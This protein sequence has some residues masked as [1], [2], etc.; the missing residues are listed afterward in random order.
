MLNFRSLAVLAPTILFWPALLRVLWVCRVPTVGALL[1]L[2]FVHVPQA[3]DL[4]LDL[5]HY[6]SLVFWLLFPF[7]FALWL[8]ALYVCARYAISGTFWAVRLGSD[9]RLS[10]SRY[11]LLRRR[12]LWAT[13]I[14]PFLI[15]A[16]G[17]GLVIYALWNADERLP[18]RVLAAKQLEQHLQTTALLAAVAMVAVFAVILLLYFLTHGKSAGDD[19]YWPTFLPAAVVIDDSTGAVVRPA[20][21]PT[22]AF[23]A[24]FWFIA[25]ALTIILVALIILPSLSVIV[26]RAY[27]AFLLL[28]VWLPLLTL[29]STASHR[30]GL[31]LIVITLGLSAVVVL[32]GG[33]RHQVRTA[34]DSNGLEHKRPS[35][36]AWIREWRRA[37][38]CLE[39]LDKCPQAILIA[40][41][42]GASRAGFF[43]AST[44]GYLMDLTCPSTKSPC[45]VTATEG[46]ALTR[47]TFAIS[48]VSGSTLGAAAWVTALQHARRGNGFPC[49]TRPVERP[50]LFGAAYEWLSR[51]FEILDREP[52]ALTKYDKRASMEGW[53]GSFVPAGAEQ[54]ETVVNSWQDCL[55]LLTVGDYLSP[56]V[57][58]LL[59]K[60]AI[61]LAPGN[62]R[63]W[64]LEDAFA[65][66]V[67]AA[68]NLV[69]EA[70]SPF[71]ANFLSL[72][73]GKMKEV[74]V[75]DERD[76]EGGAAAPDDP[77]RNEDERPTSQRDD[78]GWLPL[79]ISNG[80]SVHRG[81]RILT[82][83]I[84][85]QN[86]GDEPVFRDT[87]DVYDLINPKLSDPD[88]PEDG[89]NGCPTIDVCAG[90]IRDIPIKTV[91]TNSA[92]FPIV[93][94]EG[95]FPYAE[96]DC[97][98]RGPSVG[99]GREGN[100]DQI[101][102]GGYYEGSGL[103][104][105]FDV[106]VALL[107]KG[108]DPVV[109]VITNDPETDI[110]A[111]PPRG[112]YRESFFGSFSTP[113][114][115]VSTARSGRAYMS[116][117]AIR[118]LP[119]AL[120]ANEI[121][122][123]GAAGVGRSRPEGTVPGRLL[124]QREDAQ[125]TAN[126]LDTIPSPGVKFQIQPRALVPSGADSNADLADAQTSSSAADKASQ[127]PRTKDRSK[128]GK[129]NEDGI[130]FI[131]VKPVRNVD[132]DPMCTI[133]MNWW[134]SHPIQRALRASVLSHRNNRD[135]IDEFCSVVRHLTG[136]GACNQTAVE[137]SFEKAVEAPPATVSER[138]CLTELSGNEQ[139]DTTAP[140]PTAAAQ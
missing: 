133:S 31:P 25:G 40:A 94:T 50:L 48:S 121:Q 45:P 16:I 42:G 63:N 130:I 120:S 108:I 12:Y 132:R 73:A 7:A 26:N 9:R 117:D 92:R 135:N 49:R 28:G 20:T 33:D 41:S 46:P 18:L 127:M 83:P 110:S 101:V 27:L 47:Q 114:T 86:D 76:D 97:P 57:A 38:G 106:A 124:R 74:R 91:V 129:D 55:E 8:G 98:R 128:D 62:D 116:L 125:Q 61:P 81:N 70:P 75:H 14:V 112:S 21:R 22:R 53:H 137:K 109:L 68:M 102:D 11:D 139:P 10:K 107:S 19:R 4:F 90:D 34:E 13:R 56:A 95:D 79:L 96:K 32:E 67:R 6:A 39:S 119:P 52:D 64:M 136:E 60:D 30:T 35:I 115:A 122:R 5:R 88:C 126:G 71:D 2:A 87:T 105:V 100:F 69:D 54:S 59:T 134:L 43:T 131:D 36:D 77:Q 37:N 93:S 66:H 80:S 113:L 123:L 140:A 104:T 24:L 84:A 65:R 138:L 72:Y 29:L 111:R 58:T 17:G 1:A 103:T 99:F 85:A 51:L 3:S 118:R 44:L 89:G 23:S 78:V 82:S 15:P